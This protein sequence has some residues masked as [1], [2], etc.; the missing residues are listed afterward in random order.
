MPRLLLL[1][2]L[3]ALGGG[4]ALA[5]P[6]V[7]PLVDTIDFGPAGTVSL[8][9]APDGSGT[10][11]HAAWR[12]DGTTTDATI[13]IS[14]VDEWDNPMADVPRE[15]VW[16][17]FDAPPGTVAGCIQ[18]QDYGSVFHPDHASDLDG[19]MEWTLPLRGGGWS[20][21]PARMFIYGMPAERPDHSILPPLPIRVNSPDVD[22]DLAVDLTDIALFTQDLGGSYHYRSDFC[23]DGVIDLSDVAFFVPAIGC[24][25]P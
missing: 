3:V 14:L 1:V 9:M 13:R 11:F 23:W 17:Q 7:L 2:L 22:G 10:P 21:G 8:A 6:I 4:G 15:D 12:V 18:L 25:C 19:V 24:V 16:L 20:E 5:N